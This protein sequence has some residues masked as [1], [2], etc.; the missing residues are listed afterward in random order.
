MKISN[1]EIAGEFDTR[2][3]R[4]WRYNAQR[5]RFFRDYGVTLPD[6]AGAVD[7]GPLS[8]LRVVINPVCITVT[9]DGGEY[10]QYSFM[11]GFVTDL[12]S[13]PRIA[14]SFIDNDDIDLLAAAY[15]HDANYSCHYLQVGTGTEAE[16]S[17]L[18]RVNELFRQMIRYRGKKIKAALAHAAV[19]SIIGRSIYFKMPGRREAWTRKRVSFASNNPNYNG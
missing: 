12:A 8:Q 10:Y 15:V 11:R 9:I 1:I 14:R 6:R 3:I 18:D 19:D 17:G 5:T 16:L 7:I 13:V 2:R 4:P